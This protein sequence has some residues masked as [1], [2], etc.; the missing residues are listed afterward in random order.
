M[1]GEIFL[2]QQ[3][4]LF[5]SE[6][7]ISQAVHI[8]KNNEA[9]ALLARLLHKSLI[10]GMSDDDPNLQLVSFLEVC[11]TFKINGV[12][13]D[14]IQMRLFPF[15]LKDRAKEWLQFMPHE[16]ITTWEEL[17]TKFLA[18]FFP[19]ARTTKLRSEINNFG[20]YDMESLYEA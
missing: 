11:E 2:K 8:G 15:S 17:A 10:K 14:A 18:R 9:F 19:P 4:S 16:S 7:C 20:Q 13:S 6:P 1:L 12:T 3:D 5:S